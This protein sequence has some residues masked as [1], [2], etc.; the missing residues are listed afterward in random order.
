MA[1]TTRKAKLILAKRK[2]KQAKANAKKSGRLV[3]SPTMGI[4]A[5]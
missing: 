4:K 2:Q 5:K 1:T 3:E